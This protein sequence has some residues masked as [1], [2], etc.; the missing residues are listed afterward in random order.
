[1]KVT[2]ALIDAL[3]ENPFNTMEVGTGARNGDLRHR[4]AE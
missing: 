2:A 1:M 4:I 3:Q